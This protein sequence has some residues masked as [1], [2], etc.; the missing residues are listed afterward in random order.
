METYELPK[1]PR[2]A[3]EAHKGTFGH[4]LVLAGSPTMT[5]AAILCARGALR[6]GAGLVTIGFP[7]KLYPWFAPRV[8]CEMTLPLPQTKKGTFSW[9]AVQP[10]ME[11]LAPGTVFALGPGI[12]THPETQ[13]FVCNLVRRAPRAGVIDADGLNNLAGRLKDVEE[14][15]APRVLTPHPGEFGRLIDRPV[16]AIQADRAGILAEF[17]GRVGAVVALKGWQTLV[18]DGKKMYENTTG[19][20]G[21]ASGGVGDVLTGIV[22]GLLG[23]GMDPFDAT[24]LGVHVHGRAGDLAA[25][26]VGEVSCTALDVLDATGPAMKAVT[27]CDG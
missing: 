20:P 3:R 10:V 2:R 19:N 26:K 15:A 14:A 12:S 18:S 7:E 16:E 22:A 5:G 25:E 8:E 6:G 13:D 4:V 21:M 27:E 23:S 11:F 24:A 17:A 1:I 9:K